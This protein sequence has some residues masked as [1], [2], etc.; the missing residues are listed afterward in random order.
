MVGATVPEKLPM[1]L[2]V[3]R[4]QGEP[5]PHCETT[6]EAVYFAEH[7]TTY[8]PK[9]QTGGRVLKDRRLSRLLK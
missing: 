1:P 2:Q 7:L 3:H 9:E 5:C 4:R 8:C 6:L